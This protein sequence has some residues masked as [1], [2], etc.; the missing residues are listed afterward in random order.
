MAALQRLWTCRDGPLLR[1]YWGKADIKRTGP[2]NP[3][4]ALEV[5]PTPNRRIEINRKKAA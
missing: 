4:Q 1:R 3:Q 5:Q 2:A